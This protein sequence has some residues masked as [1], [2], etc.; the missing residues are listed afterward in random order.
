MGISLFLVYRGI[1]Y[2]QK[3]RYK[4]DFVYKRYNTNSYYV[5]LKVLNKNKENK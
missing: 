4:R 5:N 3:L 2:T 1:A